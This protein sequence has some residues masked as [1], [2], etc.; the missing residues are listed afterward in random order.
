M[1]PS[2]QDHL[3]HLDHTYTEAL[4]E[5]HASGLGVEGVVIHSG[6][7]HYHYAD[8]MAMPFQAYG[9]FRHWMPVNHPGQWLSWRPGQRPRWIQVVPDDYWHDPQIASAPDWADGFDIVRVASQAAAVAS[10]GDCT[11]LAFLGAHIERAEVAGFAAAHCNPPSL[12]ARLDWARARKTAYELTQ[13]RHANRIALRGHAAAQEAFLAGASEYQ[14]HMAFL[15]AC[16]MREEEAPYLP[17]VALNEKAAILHY[18]HKR[19]EVRSGKVL[20]IDAGARCQG[21]CS[22]ITRTLTQDSAP[23]AFIDLRD[24]MDAL[25][26]SLV[27]RVR[28]GLPYPEL[29]EATLAGITDI[30]LSQG[31]LRCDKETATRERLATVFMPHG[32]GHLLGLQVHDVGGQQRAPSGGRLPPPAHAPAL[33]TTRILEPDMVCTVEPGLYFIDSLL[34]PWL[35]RHPDWFDGAL[36]AALAPC[37]GIRIEDDVRVTQTGV[38]NLT[39]APQA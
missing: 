25:Q 5:A 14:I 28:P 8:D 21:Y 31:I 37:G 20:L 29:H 32:V 26:Q 7:L 17:I 23:T 4:L 3:N 10:L 9:H 16:D 38:E 35:A 24:A 27:A 12:L 15:L 33:R 6:E 22:D 19:T 36:I 18:Q 1:D 34:A 39:R 2:F 13:L 30:L 11:R